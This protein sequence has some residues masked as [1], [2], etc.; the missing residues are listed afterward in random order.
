MTKLD[1]QLKAGLLYSRTYQFQ[2]RLNITTQS[3]QRFFEITKNPYLSVSFGK[4][5]IILAHL[6]FSIRPET[7]MALLQSWETF[8]LHDMEQ[9]ITNFIKRWPINLTIHYKDNVSWNNWGWKQ[10]RDHGQN[11]LQNMGDELFHDWDGLI[12]GLSKDESFARRMT[13]SN[14]NTDW[15][16]IFQYKNGKFRCTPIQFWNQ[17]DLA[18]YIAAYDIPLLAAYHQ[19]GLETRTTARITK[20]CA[21]MNGLLDLKYRNI[22][23]YN[24]IVKRFP[25]LTAKA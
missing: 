17:M 14:S 10:T 6:I 12:M 25:E 23:D 20:N 7:R 13:C 9:V 11:D 5:S 24:K 18:A 15:K 21:E 1:K 2:R 16:T 22:S 19:N 3:L 4:Q 8:M